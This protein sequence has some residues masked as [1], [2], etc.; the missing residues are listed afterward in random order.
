MRIPAFVLNFPL[1][2]GAIQEVSVRA[3]RRRQQSFLRHQATKLSWSDLRYYAAGHGY[4]KKF[5][6]ACRYE[7][8]RRNSSHILSGF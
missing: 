7:I 1:F 2:R 4:N 5:A 3:F 6:E 8:N